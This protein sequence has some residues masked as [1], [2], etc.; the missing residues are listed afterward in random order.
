MYLTMLWPKPCASHI[1]MAYRHI[2]TGN[3]HRYLNTLLVQACCE[4]DIST[5]S[6][7][8]EQF[9]PEQFNKFNKKLNKKQRKNAFS[10]TLCCLLLKG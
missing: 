4:T 7:V 6:N 3:V 2:W 1:G 9:K 5:V 8:N 10:L